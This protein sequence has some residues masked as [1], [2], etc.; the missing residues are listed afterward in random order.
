MQSG[1]KVIQAKANV[2]LKEGLFKKRNGEVIDLKQL[3]PEEKYEI[4]YGETDRYR[5]GPA[6]GYVDPL[7]LACSFRSVLDVGCGVGLSLLGFIIRKKIAKGTELC[8]YCLNNFLFPFVASGIVKEAR[9]QK[10]PYPDNSFDMVF[11]VDVL[12]HIPE[13]DVTLVLSELHRVSSKY[14]FLGISMAKDI[15]MEK[16]GIDLQLHETV[17]DKKWWGERCETA[18]M[19]F[20]QELPGM[21][22]GKLV[23]RANAGSWLFSK[24]GCDE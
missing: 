8:K 2:P 12:E 13:G 3:K 11:C 15:G 16:L 22:G 17:Q 19:K 20:V 4:A 14:I 9:A 23:N 18:G 5:A 6:I 1:E 10:L 7:I 24:G 21:Y